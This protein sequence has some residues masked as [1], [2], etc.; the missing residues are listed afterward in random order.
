MAHVFDQDYAAA[1]VAVNLLSHVR[2]IL[3]MDKAYT[4][5]S[6]QYL[7]DNAC[8]KKEAGQGETD[9]DSS[10]LTAKDCL[11]FVFKE[12]IPKEDDWTHLGCLSKP[13]SAY[14][15]A[16]VYMKGKVIEPEDLNEAI[17]FMVQQPIG[18]KL[19]VFSPELDDHVGE[20]GIYIGR[21]SDETR[22][23]GLVEVMIVA[24]KRITGEQPI[25][26]VKMYHKNKKD[27]LVTVALDTKS[28]PLLVDFFLPLLSR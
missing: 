28:G 17:I 27:T 15:P 20:N 9:R 8:S 19:H 22:Y 18:A 10:K 25:A 12:G 2:L 16:R 7:L 24:M 5:Y 11:E 21:S 6:A 1:A 4:N 14:N 3:K 13:P 23:V 26:T